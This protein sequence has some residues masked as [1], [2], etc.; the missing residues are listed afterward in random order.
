MSDKFVGGDWNGAECSWQSVEYPRSNVAI[1]GP[2]TTMTGDGIFRV[3]KR[4]PENSRRWI[5]VGRT[6][7]LESAYV[8][9]EAALEEYL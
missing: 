2:G 9:G 4:D 7:N 6:D 1:Y 8:L 5:L 3:E